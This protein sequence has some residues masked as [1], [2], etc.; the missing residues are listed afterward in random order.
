LAAPKGKSPRIRYGNTEAF[1]LEDQV[2]YSN[3]DPPAIML[4]AVA[5]QEHMGENPKEI[6]LEQERN[7][8]GFPFDLKF[9]FPMLYV[10]ASTRMDRDEADNLLH[11]LQRLI[12][13]RRQVENY[14]GD[15]VLDEITREIAEARAR[16]AL[17]A[18]GRPEVWSPLMQLPEAVPPPPPSVP[19]GPEPSNSIMWA[20]VPPILKLIRD[21]DLDNPT[22]QAARLWLRSI[23]AIKNEEAELSRLLAESGLCPETLVAGPQR[24]EFDR[25][26]PRGASNWKV[27]GAFGCSTCLIPAQPGLVHY[28]QHVLGKQHKVI[29]ERLILYVT[30]FA[31]PAA[32]VERG[33]LCKICLKV[34]YRSLDEHE[35]SN[36]HKVS[37][38]AWP[39]PP[40]QDD[41]RMA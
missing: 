16:A 31:Y 11:R 5:A 9:A 35:R 3:K 28:I 17:S 24:P 4:A 12:E 14:D 41:E 19:R 37:M 26:L 10:Q 18:G 33:R 29:L 30:S 27:R 38:R 7:P 22:E 23:T 6:V 32:V 39:P 2:I 20:S 8:P 36:R 13:F 15:A 1:A 34:T 25:F 21:G 40:P